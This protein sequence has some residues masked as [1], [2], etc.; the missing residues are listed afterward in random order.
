MGVIVAVMIY[1]IG[2]MGWRQPEIFAHGE[3]LNSP[4]KYKR[5]SLNGE[6]AEKYKNR[7]A[8]IMKTDKP[9]L[10][11][12]L[13]I[14]ELAD[15]INVPAYQLSQLINEHFGQN[16]FEFINSHRIEEAKQRLSDPKLS[17]YSILAIA[18]DAGFNSKS[19]FNTAFKKY[20]GKTPSQ[21]REQFI[22][23]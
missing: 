20:T 4:E 1:S 13:T 3:L 21:F 15:K 6:Q 11:H 7:L 8:K 23:L 22:Q 5:S 17:H 14:K 18:Y 10:N 12:S 19:V 9:F 2:Y 16:F